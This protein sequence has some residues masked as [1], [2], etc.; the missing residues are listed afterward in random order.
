MITVS[1]HG[2]SSVPWL[3][4]IT[5]PEANTGSILFG[6]IDTAKYTGNLVSVDVYPSPSRPGTNITEFLVALTSISVTSSSGTD[7]LTPSNYAL[8]VVL[9]SGSSITTL[10]ADIVSLIYREFAATNSSDFGPGIVSCTTE[11]NSGTIN[12][13]FGGP[14]GPTIKVPMSE[15]VDPVLLATGEQATGSD[16][17]PV[18]QLGITAQDPS[19]MDSITFGDT[20]LRSAYVVYDMY[21]NQIAL[22][23]TDF[24]AATSNVVAFASMGAAIP[25]AATATGQAAV[26][27]VATA[28]ASQLSTLA[29]ASGLKN[30]ANRGLEPLSLLQLLV[31]FSSISLIAGCLL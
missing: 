17:T 28:P 31:F 6:G 18:C 3:L 30:A 8:G 29:A 19:S 15:I 11:H 22:A 27:P 5:L 2:E 20:F 4:L 14:G 16:G 9:D 13:G 23:Q 26:T 12:F 21:N 10:P 7:Q 25:S 1:P 24:N